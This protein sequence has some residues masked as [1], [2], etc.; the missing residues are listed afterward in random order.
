MFKV[1][2]LIVSNFA[3]LKLQ[4]VQNIEA[5]STGQEI[6]THLKQTPT[7]DRDIWVTALR[8]LNDLDYVHPNIGKV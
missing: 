6:L 3:S 8:K 2:V 1:F 4:V 5:A 7:V